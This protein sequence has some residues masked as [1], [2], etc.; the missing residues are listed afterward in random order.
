MT[1][2]GNICPMNLSN[3]VLIMAFSA[4][5]LL[6]IAPSR[7]VMLRGQIGLLQKVQLLCCMSLDFLL[8][9]GEKLLVLLFMSGIDL[10]LLQSKEP[11]HM[12]SGLVK[13]QILA[14][15]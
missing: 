8:A 13:S 1:R 7:M 15:F 6:G 10:L 5:T 3:S 4:A 12:S 11:L 9:S 2:E 14:E